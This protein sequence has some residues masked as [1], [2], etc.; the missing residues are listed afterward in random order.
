MRF[1]SSSPTRFF[2]AFNDFHEF[3]RKE[4]AQLIQN[5][6]LAVIKDKCSAYLVSLKQFM[7]KY[8]QPKVFPGGASVRRYDQESD[9][10][11]TVDNNSTVDDFSLVHKYRKVLKWSPEKLYMKAELERNYVEK[12]L[13]EVKEDLD[14]FVMPDIDESGMGTLSHLTD[15]IGKL[16]RQDSAMSAFSAISGASAMSG[17]F[18][19][20]YSKGSDDSDVDK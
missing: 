10:G 20:S 8:V 15:S 11:S 2:Q 9:T 4:N 19:R 5:D 17:S 12:L 13:E 1:A 18:S 3:N 6:R 16:I 7:S 14:S